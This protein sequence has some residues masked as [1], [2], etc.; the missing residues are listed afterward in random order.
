MSASPPTAIPTTPPEP[1]GTPRTLPVPAVPLSNG[2][3]A[4]PQSNP[5]LRVQQTGRRTKRRHF[6][7]AV[8][9]VTSLI[10][11]DLVVLL[12][13][14]ESLHLL[15]ELAWSAGTVGTFFPSGFMGGLWELRLDSL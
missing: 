9:R 12:A 8:G 11:L 3:G 1:L 10:A 7:R 5:R 13:A 2:H 14:R 15:R 6:S 4:S